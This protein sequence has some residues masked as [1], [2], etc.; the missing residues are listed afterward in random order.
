MT[1]V[2]LPAFVP[3]LAPLE[4][5]AK[6]A[7]SAES[8]PSPCPPPVIGSQINLIS[9]IRDKVDIKSSQKKNELK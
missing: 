8:S 1:L 6:E 5:L 9:V 2:I 4:A 3:T 7:G